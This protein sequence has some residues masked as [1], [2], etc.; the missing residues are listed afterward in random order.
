MARFPSKTNALAY[1]R[2][3]GI[4]FG[5]I[6]DIGTHAETAELRNAFPNNRHLLFEPAEEFFP[7][8]SHNYAGMDYELIPLAVSDID[9]IGRL[10]KTSIDGGDVSHSTLVYAEDADQPMVIDVKTVRL[11][12]FLTEREEPKPYLLKVDV[13]GFEV[14]ILRGAERI[15]QDIDCIIVEATAETMAE[16]LQYIAERGFQLFDIV[17][18]CYYSG[19]FSQADLIFVSRRL[20]EKNPRLRPWQTEEFNWKKWLPVSDYERLIPGEEI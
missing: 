18:Q 3:I 16:R 2:E 5:T 11:D 1:M 7:K 4:Q 12:T 14:P 15:W 13:D 6:L 17:D 9:G 8:I 19:V 20:R 10:K